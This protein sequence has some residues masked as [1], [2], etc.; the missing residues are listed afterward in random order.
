M[1]K[2]GILG[3]L[4][5]FVDDYVVLVEEGELVYELVI[6]YVDGIKKIIS[7]FKVIF[8]VSGVKFIF[9]FFFEGEVV[10]IY[11]FIIVIDSVV[12]KIEIIG[13][14]WGIN[15]FSIFKIVYLGKVDVKY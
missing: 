6:I 14:D 5:I 4:G 2:L 9:I 8:V 12:G 11:F 7:M 15:N 13:V 3:I 1:G 10:R